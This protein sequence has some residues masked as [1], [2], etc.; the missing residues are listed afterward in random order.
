MEIILLRHGKPKVE[1]EGYF[2]AKELKQLVVA[3]ENSAII[4]EPTKELKNNFENYYVVCSNLP[5]SID[6]AEKLGFKNINLSGALFRETDLPHFDKG[7]LKLHVVVWLILLRLMWLF[8][9]SKNGESF[10]EAKKRSKKAANE[11]TLLAQENENIIV[12]GHGLFNRLITKQLRLSGWQDT[13]FV[14][15]R[16]WEFN[17][18]TVKK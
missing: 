18:F 13:G 6:S 14:G 8:G 7:F 2:S 15:R 3:Y 16:Y 1:L 4:D 12:V 10:S 5:R 17:T 9:F 11:L